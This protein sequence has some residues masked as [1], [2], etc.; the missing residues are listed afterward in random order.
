M[1]KR[2]PRRH[3]HRYNR[4]PN[5]LQPIIGIVVIIGVLFFLGSWVLN[6]FGVGNTIS[7]TAVTLMVEGGGN[8][9]VSIEG[10]EFKR[11]ENDQKLFPGDTVTTGPGGHAQ[12]Y[13]FDGSRGRLDE[14]SE[15]AIVESYV[16]ETM[17]KINVR[18]TQGALWIST[19][20]L[21]T[22]SGAIV[23]S[24]NTPVL[25]AK[26]PSRSESIIRSRSIVVFAA[27]GIGV[28]IE[29]KDIVIP[30]IVGEGQQFTMPS[31]I[32]SDEDLY[33]YRSPLDP[34]A[35][36]SS[37]VADSRKSGRARTSG[38]ET[39]SPV[40]VNAGNETLVVLSPENDITVQKSVI[41]V[42]GTISKA[43]NR[44]RINGYTAEIDEKTGTFNLELALP[45]QDEVE[46]IIAALDEGGDLLSEV[47]RQIKRDREPPE[48]PTITSPATNGQTYRTVRGRFTIDGTAARGTT[49][50]VVN[51]YRLQLF[52]PGDERWSYLASTTI[53]NLKPGKNIY[54]V[55]AF[56]EGGYKSD[57]ATLT[58]LIEE[59]Q[60]GVVDTPSTGDSSS[61]VAVQ[62]ASSSSEGY[63]PKDND[64]IQPGSLRVFAPT[65]GDEHTAT[66][67]AVLI[68][69]NTSTATDSIWVNDYR[70]RLYE[71]GK[72]FWNYIADIGLGTMSRGRNFY[73][74]VALDAAGRVLDKANY[75]VIFRPGRN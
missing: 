6:L 31:E 63:T 8:V 14:L 51:D 17:S 20:T 29:N 36:K 65:S 32:K 49:S 54:N 61:S 66:G 70:L 15:I 42:S 30:I 5:V 27:D 21:Q 48:A 52:K 1:R 69:G 16:G 37:F 59:G 67:S 33:K 11:A 60:E 46:I 10:G 25:E 64:P 74:I 62:Q 75:V 18:V 22:F 58:I 55:Y 43:V 23:R 3:G 38:G 39:T 72:D 47:R 41:V 44:V 7:R 57:V 9:R 73:Q 45:E 4:Q 56:N 71:P 26:L 19:P 50:I 2:V 28:T 35:L 34:L 40:V 13:F 24:I 53:D 12:L 68:E